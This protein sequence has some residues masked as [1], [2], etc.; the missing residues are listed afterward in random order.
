MKSPTET[1]YHLGWEPEAVKAY[2]KEHLKAGDLV[3]SV[4]Q[5]NAGP[6]LTDYR[7]MTVSSHT[8][9]RFKLTQSTGHNC[10]SS[11]FYFKGV[12]CAE[13]KGQTRIIPYHA[14]LKFLLFGSGEINGL[15]H[16]FVT[17]DNVLKLNAH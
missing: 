4:M 7:F 3:V 2:F 9:V 1:E 5:T 11:T 13:P 15:R 17:D 12:S 10:I 8:K 14:E 16:N 6:N